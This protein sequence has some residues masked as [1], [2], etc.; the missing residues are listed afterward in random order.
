MS[1]DLFK[2][3]PQDQFKHLRDQCW[4]YN[5]HPDMI[6][7]D[8]NGNPHPCG[9]DSHK[10]ALLIVRECMEQIDDGNS[11]HAGGNI[12]AINRIKELLNERLRELLE[13]ATE[14]HDEWRTGQTHHV[15]NHKMFAEL[16][17]TEVTDILSTYRTKVAFYDG[18]EYNCEHPITAIRKHFGVKE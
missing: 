14:V 10:F 13:Q 1:N 18:I 3:P 11:D 7:E 6:D 9:F 15:V 2:N 5:T 16:I 4:I 17:L 8:S 12:D